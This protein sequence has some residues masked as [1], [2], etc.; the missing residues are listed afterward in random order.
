MLA[1]Y[2]TAEMMKQGLFV[3]SPIAHCHNLAE[4]YGMPGDID[5]WRGYD[6]H[7]ISVS[8]ALV[9]LMIPGWTESRGLA[10]EVAFAESMEKPIYSA[11]LTARNEI[12]IAEKTGL[13][14]S[15][16]VPVS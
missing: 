12:Y 13:S 4:R 8:G 5:Y 3:F 7:L 2:V 10:H 1:E 14:R 6:E 15:F 16:R 9:V 11:I